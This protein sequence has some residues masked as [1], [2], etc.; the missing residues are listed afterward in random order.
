MTRFNKFGGDETSTIESSVDDAVSTEQK[1]RSERL[2]TAVRAAGGNRVVSRSSGVPV[3]TL[4]SY[5]AGRDMK[6]GTLIAL[7]SACG[8]SLEW[9]ATGKEDPSAPAPAPTAPTSPPKLFSIVDMDLFG[10]VITKAISLLTDEGA[11]P[12]GRAFAQIICI[13][14]DEAKERAAAERGSK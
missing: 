11:N 2:R 9:L 10:A 12:E 7:A 5:I 14:Y 8:V 3:G 1:T 6:V 4:D 13:L